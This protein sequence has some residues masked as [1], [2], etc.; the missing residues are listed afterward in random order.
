MSL[1][2]LA[3]GAVA[4]QQEPAKSAAVP[5][6]YEDIEVMR[7]LL[8]RAIR[9]QQAGRHLAGAGVRSGSVAFSP[10][11]RLLASVYQGRVLKWDTATG[12]LLGVTGLGAAG[13]PDV[14]GVY[15]KGY[16]V[17]FT[18][19]LP[20]QPLGTGGGS[21]RPGAKP[22]SEW[23]RVRRELRGEKVEGLAAGRP[24][25]APRLDQ[26]ILRVLAQNGQHFTELGEKERLTVVITFRGEAGLPAGGLTIGQIDPKRLE[27]LREFLKAHPE[28]A[29]QY[30]A[31]LDALV[32]Q[33]A[34]TGGT[35][36]GAFGAPPSPGR[37][38]EL[39]ADLQLKQGRYK[40]AVAAYQRAL[41]MK[42][43]S[44][45]AGPVYAKLAQAYLGLQASTADEAQRQAILKGL[46]FLRR[47]QQ[48]RAG[49]AKGGEPLRGAPYGQ[50]IITAPK[51]LLERSGPGG[52]S[53]EQFR[54]EASVH[55]RP[56]RAPE[57]K[58]GNR[59]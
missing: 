31:Q 18:L 33:A 55:F 41:E 39:L 3:P 42:P 57:R 7:R 20:P 26:T 45:H 25:R 30:A 6:M 49:G 23:D 27:S 46:E 50:L 19:T 14:E 16:G 13:G 24:E 9:E 54:R 52:L 35:R 32:K 34:A 11:G 28:A 21:A 29:K 56:I 5:Q 44:A 22:L 17:V 2:L 15:L 43:D 38:Y 37:D 51:S 48:E 8:T 1:G 53:P 12:K 36:R 47:L 4:A 10:D 59:P 58:T 40:E